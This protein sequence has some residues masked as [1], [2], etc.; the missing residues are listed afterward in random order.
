MISAVNSEVVAEPK[1][2]RNY[3]KKDAK[4]SFRM[5]LHTTHVGSSDLACVDNIERG[6]GDVIGD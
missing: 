4:K 6:G 3:Q 2:R 5:T 1:S